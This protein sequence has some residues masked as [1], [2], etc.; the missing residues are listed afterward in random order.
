MPQSRRSFLTAGVPAS[1]GLSPSLLSARG[2]EAAV[3]EGADAEQVRE[4]LAEI[5]INSNENPLGPGEKATQAFARGLLDSGRYP[6]NARPSMGDLR[7][8]IARRLSVRPENVSLGA[9]S[10]EVLRTAV[11]LYTSSSRAL[12]TATPSF[13]QPEGMA[14]QLGVGVRK[15]PVDKDGRLD[16]EPMVKASRWAGLVFFCNPNNPTGGVHSAR[17]VADF[18]GRVRRDSPDTAILI[19]EAYH[20]YVTDTGYASALPLALE[21]PNVFITRT[22]SKAYGM[23]GLRI[24]YAVGQP[25]TIEAFNRWAITFNQNSASVAAGVASVNDPAHIEVESAR[26]AEV[27]RFTT[28]FFQDKGFRVLPSET[29]FVFVELGRPA[30]D[31]RDECA[32]QRVMVGRDFPPMEKTHT[33]ISLGT[34]DEMKRAT[35][36]FARVLGATRLGQD[37]GRPA[38]RAAR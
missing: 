4:N 14:A 6:T 12:V 10:W 35:E 13:E 28:R 8:S 7:E 20:D 23:A 15:V 33:R 21:H 11:R 1:A 27:R 26:N 25:R 5:R 37:L 9:G 30:K 18:V 32:K 22:F 19:D 36:V 3:A 31:F 17:A 38:E 29:N 34:M 24:G 2:R 16:L